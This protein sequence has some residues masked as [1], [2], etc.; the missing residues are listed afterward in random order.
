MPQN[1]QEIFLS[2]A[3]EKY[4]KE[5]LLVLEE[6]QQKQTLLKKCKKASEMLKLLKKGLLWCWFWCGSRPP[7]YC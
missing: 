6:N 7:P 1:K 2:K 4:S 5:H 3:S